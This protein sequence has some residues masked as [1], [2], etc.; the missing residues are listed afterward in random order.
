MSDRTGGG[1]VSVRGYRVAC[2]ILYACRIVF[3]SGTRCVNRVAPGERRSSIF[4]WNGGGGCG[5]FG[6]AEW[7]W[8]EESGCGCGW[9]WGGDRWFGNNG[10]N[11]DGRI[12]DV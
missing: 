5:G 11:G 4:R 1:T 12:E 7:E 9:D 3:C 10:G 6:G 8:E 2:M